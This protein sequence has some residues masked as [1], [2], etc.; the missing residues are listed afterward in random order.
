METKETKETKRTPI[1]RVDLA[2]YEKTH[3]VHVSGTD[4]NLY[5]IA[6]LIISL[7][8]TLTETHPATKDQFKEIFYT[9]FYGE[10]EMTDDKQ[11]ETLEELKKDYDKLN[12]EYLEMK[13]I[14]MKLLRGERLTEEERLYVSI[15]DS[16]DE[17]FNK[18]ERK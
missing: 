9:Y 5:N 12:I 14:L 7:I 3:D 13:K 10:L 6:Y 11:E 1:V 18:G 16:L 8:E 2:L 4:S 17:H 15:L